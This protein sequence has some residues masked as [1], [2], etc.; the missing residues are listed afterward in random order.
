LVFKQES[1]QEDD[2]NK[3]PPPAPAPSSPKPELSDI[4]ALALDLKSKVE[5]SRS[6]LMLVG[7]G[8]AGKT[9]F[10]H[11]APGTMT[12]EKYK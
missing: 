10:H 11:L 2:T 8:R 5:W 12:E 4:V 9:A 3:S 6:P 1:S 7:P